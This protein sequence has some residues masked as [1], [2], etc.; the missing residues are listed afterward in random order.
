MRRVGVC[1]CTLVCAREWVGYALAHYW[2]ESR[3]VQGAYIFC[4]LLQCPSEDRPEAKM[5]SEVGL[6]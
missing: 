5:K 1:K 4:A 6:G 2:S 3:E